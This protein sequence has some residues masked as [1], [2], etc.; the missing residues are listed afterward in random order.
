[1]AN[2]L[3]ALGTVGEANAHY[4]EMMAASVDAMENGISLGKICQAAWSSE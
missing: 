3:A 2:E 1:M 4:R